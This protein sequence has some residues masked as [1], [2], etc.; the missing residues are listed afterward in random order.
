MRKDEAGTAAALQQHMRL[1]HNFW[2]I[3]QRIQ[4]AAK[5]TPSKSVS[6]FNGDGETD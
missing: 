1:K 3:Q 6:N 2:I 5:L 4:I